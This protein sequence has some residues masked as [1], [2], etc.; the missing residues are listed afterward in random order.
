MTGNDDGGAATG[1]MSGITEDTPDQAGVPGEAGSIDGVS[2]AGA[3]PETYDVSGNADGSGESPGQ[4]GGAAEA[5]SGEGL[6]SGDTGG[7][8]GTSDL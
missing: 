8:T 1:G 7:V 5:E 3:P 6:V 4:E 2:A